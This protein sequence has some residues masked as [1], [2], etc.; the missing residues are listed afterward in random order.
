MRVGSCRWDTRKEGRL[1]ESAQR[2]AR[3]WRGLN[4]LCWVYQ[5]DALPKSISGA[6]WLGAMGQTKRFARSR[7]MS[8]MVGMAGIA[9]ATSGL[10]TG[11]LLAELHPA[12]LLAPR[13]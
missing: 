6:C 4:S 12:C 9:P 7:V 8:A 2:R 10:K 1:S 3:S 11:A 13:G 5:T